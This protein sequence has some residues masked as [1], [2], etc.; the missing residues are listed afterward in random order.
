MLKRGAS[1]VVTMAIA[2]KVE[3]F[4]P[5]VWSLLDADV[6]I[7]IRGE[8]GAARPATHGVGIEELGTQ[9]TPLTVIA[10]CASAWTLLVYER[11]ALAL[12]LG[13]L[14]W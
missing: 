14:C 10:T 4:E 5:E 12:A 2:S 9:H 6:M 11:F 3:P 1:R 7:D 13:D 8:V